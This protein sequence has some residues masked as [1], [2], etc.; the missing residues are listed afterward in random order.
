MLV[1]GRGQGVSIPGARPADGFFDPVD[2]T[3]PYAIVLRR[4]LKGGR[5][6]FALDQPLGYWDRQVGWI[7][8]PN[9]VD[10]F[11]TDLASVPRVFTW[12]VPPT[13]THLPAALIHDGLI[14]EPGEPQSYTAEKGTIDRPTADEVFRRAMRDLGT[15]RLRSWLV[16]S[17]VTIGTMVGPGAK[18]RA[19]QIAVLAA[20]IGTVLVLGALATIDLLD[21][22]APLFW[23]GDRPFLVELA[24]GF[25]AAVIISGLLSLLWGRRWQAGWIAGVALALLIHVTLAVSVVIAVFNSL[26][27]FFEGQVLKAVA[28]ALAAGGAVIG[29]LAIVW[30]AARPDFLTPVW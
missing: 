13:G 19:G 14:D 26:D 6:I 2:P 24:S 12:L 5:E 8:V 22:R 3:R 9:D 21:W 4:L 23:M 7:V 20:T 1:N 18:R 16:W 27:R 25:L 11:R 28:W 29:L 15:S 17:A 30:W 10:A